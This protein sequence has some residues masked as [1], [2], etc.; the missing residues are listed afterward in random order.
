MSTF[1]FEI[2]AATATAMTM[3]YSPSLRLSMAG[4]LYVPMGWSLVSWRGLLW[5]VGCPGWIFNSYGSID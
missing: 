1:R 5:L 2:L 3:T 4:R